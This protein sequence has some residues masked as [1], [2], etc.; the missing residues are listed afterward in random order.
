MEAHDDEGRERLRRERNLLE[1]KFE[2]NVKWDFLTLSDE[3]VE[4]AERRARRPGGS[5][6]EKKYRDEDE[7]KTEAKD[8]SVVDDWADEKHVCDYVVEP[9]VGVP[10]PRIP[11]EAGATSQLVLQG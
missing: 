5:G 7:M 10:A 3:S 8:G 4:R 11:E 9:A 6:S 1:S 2:P